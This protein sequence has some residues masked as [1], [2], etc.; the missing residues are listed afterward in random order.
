M[1]GEL[2]AT[3]APP[4]RPVGAGVVIADGGARGPRRAVDAA[5]GRADGP[6]VRM[7]RWR[8]LQTGH[9]HLSAS[10]PVAREA[11]C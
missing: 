8:R 11:C 7:R 5:D 4:D 9:R 1:Q 10:S 2:V 3:P 6:R